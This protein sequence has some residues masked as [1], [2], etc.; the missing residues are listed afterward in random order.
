LFGAVVMVAD[1][2]SLLETAERVRPALLM[3]DL[4][5]AKKDVA[6]LI[7]RLKESSPGSKVVILSVHDEPAV[8]QA[9]LDAGADGFLVKCR[10]GSELMPAV[11]AVLRG[12]RFVSSKSR[13]EGRKE[14]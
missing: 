3:V 13:R 7:S 1:E 12:E 14:A 10:I 11:D 6:R 4:T 2:S 9:V 8:A 5:L